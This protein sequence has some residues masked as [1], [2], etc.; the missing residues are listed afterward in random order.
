MDFFKKNL[1]FH[2]IEVKSM[3]VSKTFNLIYNG[4]NLKKLGYLD[5]WAS[6][7]GFKRNSEKEGIE[8]GRPMNLG[9]GFIFKSKLGINAAGK[10]KELEREDEWI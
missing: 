8:K 7:V 9:L 3:L 4:Y 10:R 5:L 1:I 2:V 6:G